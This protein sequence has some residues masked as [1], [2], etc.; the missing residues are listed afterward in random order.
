[1]TF[2]DIFP[3]QSRAHELLGDFWFNGEP[4]SVAGHRGDVIL[5]D[6]W[7]FTSIESLHSIP[8]V[9]EW[10]KRYS[11]SRLVVVGVHTPRFP[12]GRDP[13]R[14]QQAI[15]QLDIQYPVVMDNDHLV[16]THYGN[17]V[18]PT[19]QLIDLDG[20]IRYRGLGEGSYV[21]LER[22]LQHLLMD[23]SPLEEFPDIIAPLRDAD[24]S[25]AVLYKCTPEVFAGYLRGSIGN[26]EGYSPESVVDYV[27]P[28]IYID[29]R[30]YLHGPWLNERNCQT[31]SGEEGSGHMVFPYTGSELYIVLEPSRNQSATVSVLQDNIPLTKENKGDDVSFGAGGM[32]TIVVREPRLFSVARNSEHGQHIIKLIPQKGKLGVYAFSCVSAVIPEVIVGG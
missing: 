6:F 14:I 20:F 31:W 23:A 19:K 10:Y 22:A 25:E 4:I 18:W 26:N 32:S 3:R 1:M 11:S 27:D 7:D 21:A 9:R 13:E 8:Y 2:L 30:I 29:G 15:R 17:R 28:E 12:F 24:H 5:L 16:W